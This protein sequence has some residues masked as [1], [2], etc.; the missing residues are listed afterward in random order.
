[1]TAPGESRTNDPTFVRGEGAAASGR[2]NERLSEMDL[3]QLYALHALLVERSVSGAAKRL[4]RSQPTLSAVLARLRRYFHDELLVRRGNIYALTSFAEQLLPLTSVAVATV[5]RVFSAEPVFAPASTQ[6]EFSIVAS[7]Y[8]MGVVGRLLVAKLLA[9]A[10]L[11]RVRFVAP[12]PEAISR[13]DEF[14]RTVDGLLLPHGYIDLPRHQD[15]Y[16][17][18]WVCIV[19]SDNTRVGSELT[20][21]DLNELSWIA[22]YEDPL[23][24]VP[25]WRQ[26][27]ILGITPRVCA[28]ADT[29][30]ALPE[31]VRGTEAI[32]L[33]QYRVASLAVAKG[34]VR[35]LDCP[36]DAA[37]IIESFWWHPMHDSD[38][39]HIWLRGIL[40]RLSSE[41]RAADE[42]RL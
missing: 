39:A 6:R 41:L 35:V 19:S 26:M 31:L 28:V 4:A 21:A 18:R 30:L 20:M 25:A 10:P 3:P 23:I 37:P 1:M 38:P 5:E 32:S 11:A 13:R 7:D 40:R 16:A 12:T 8:G 29:F 36:F 24:R 27:E 9:E 22:T 2:P 33:V 34:Q 17:D 42:Q 14:Y 15:L